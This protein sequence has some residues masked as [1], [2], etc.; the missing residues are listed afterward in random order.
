MMQDPSP[1]DGHTVL[2]TTLLDLVSNVGSLGCGEEEVVDRVVSLLWSGEVLLTG[3]FRG[4]PVE[5]LFPRPEP[6]TPESPAA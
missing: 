6:P 3:N 4:I 2:Q 1:N 5:T